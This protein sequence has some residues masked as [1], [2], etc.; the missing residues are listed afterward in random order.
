MINS[1]KAFISLDSKSIFTKKLLESI[2]VADLNS[3]EPSMAGFVLQKGSGPS[4]S[5]SVVNGAL[6]I[7]GINY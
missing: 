3:L 6:K 1:E 5:F 7:Q 4:I 2:K